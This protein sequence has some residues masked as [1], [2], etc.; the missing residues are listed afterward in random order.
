MRRIRDLRES[1]R[2][3][4]G[5]PVLDR[6]ALALGLVGAILAALVLTVACGVLVWPAIENRRAERVLAESLGTKAQVIARYERVEPND[7]ALELERLAASLGLNLAP[8]R[9]DRRMG[10]FD[11]S[12]EAAREEFFDLIGAAVPELLSHMR[13]ARTLGVPEPSGKVM[14]YIESKAT[15]LA[16]VRNHLRERPLPRWECG[17]RT[18]DDPAPAL[19]DLIKLEQ[20]LALD[21]LIAIREGDR[22][23]ALADVE[24]GWRLAQSLEPTPHFLTHTV[25]LNSLRIQLVVLRQIVPPSPEWIERLERV[26]IRE[27]SFDAMRTHPWWFF[28]FYQKNLERSPKGR[29]DNALWD[30]LLDLATSEYARRTIPVIDELERRAGLCPLSGRMELDGPKLGPSEWNPVA[31]LVFPPDEGATL[32]ESA[33]FVGATE[34]ELE[35]TLRWLGFLEDTLARADAGSVPD[36]VERWVE[37]STACLGE[38]WSYERTLER[39]RLRFSRDDPWMKGP[40]PPQPSE[41]VADIEK[42]NTHSREVH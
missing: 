39:I 8:R 34:Y 14:T 24:S 5:K 37:P 12:R 7:S 35:L 29:T 11:A 32:R 16:D 17:L 20:L 10:N 25:R 31:G 21:A 36:A 33:V 2:D 42:L 15:A 23:R 28:H 13:S 18:L 27:P 38:S 1:I 22:Q 4:F 30:W 40:L 19:L 41:L 9:T 6:M 26:E 3:R